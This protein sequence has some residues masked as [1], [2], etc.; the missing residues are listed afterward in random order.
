MEAAHLLACTGSNAFKAHLCN[1]CAHEA[2]A[3]NSDALHW[4]G[5]LAEALGH[6]LA[7]TLSEEDR[8]Q[9]CTHMNGHVNTA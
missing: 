2:S 4:L 5:H 3:N 1:A 6:L 8:D 7:S 9:S